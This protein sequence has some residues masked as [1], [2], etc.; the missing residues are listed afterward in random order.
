MNACGVA[1]AMLQRHSWAPTPSNASTV[2]VGTIPTVP[3]LS[4][5]QPGGGKVRCRLM[6]LEWGGGPV[7]VRVGESPMHGEGVQRVRSVNAD[8]G[9][10]W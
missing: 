2:N 7:V 3:D 10:R 5:S 4:G 9:G 8:R 6:R 1:M